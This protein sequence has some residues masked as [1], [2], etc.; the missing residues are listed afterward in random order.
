[1]SNFDTKKYTTFIGHILNYHHQKIDDLRSYH[2]EL[3]IDYKEILVVRN[4]RIVN[5]SGIESMFQIIDLIKKHRDKFNITG[6]FY[7][8][9]DYDVYSYT[10]SFI[11]SVIYKIKGFYT[12]YKG[13]VLQC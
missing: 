9:R 2:S 10:N 4:N 1:M 11:E 8:D 6:L 7:I 5:R 12:K 13:Y 3:F